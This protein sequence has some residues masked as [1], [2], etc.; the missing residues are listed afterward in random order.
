M[1]IIDTAIGMH[2]ARSLGKAID[3]DKVGRWI[4]VQIV[5]KIVISILMSVFLPARLIWRWTGS[6]RT[7]GTTRFIRFVIYTIIAYSVI[8]GILMTLFAQ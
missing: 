2:K 1:G 4:T 8:A 5:I 7:D 6:K 3:E